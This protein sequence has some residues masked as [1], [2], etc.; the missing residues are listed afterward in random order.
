MKSQT[1]LEKEIKMNNGAIK[2]IF[3][4]PSKLQLVEGKKIGRV[5]RIREKSKGVKIPEDR[6]LIK[7][8]LVPKLAQNEPKGSLKKN[9]KHQRLNRVRKRRMVTLFKKKNF[10]KSKSSTKKKSPENEQIDE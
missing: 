5:S 4:V 1:K 10:T 9:K 6:K 2:Y 3:I 8:K 7:S